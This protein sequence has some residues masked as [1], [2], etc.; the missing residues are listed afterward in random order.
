MLKRINALLLILISIFLV[1]CVDPTQDTSKDAKTLIIRKITC[2]VGERVQIRVLNLEEGETV[3]FSYDSDAI[4][5]EDGFVEGMLAGQTVQV[6]ATSSKGGRGSFTVEVE[7]DNYSPTFDQSSWFNEINIDKVQNLRQDFPLGIDIST[8]YE[9]LDKGGKFYNHEGLRQ[10]VYQ[11]L[12]NNGVNYVRLRLW[13]DPYKTV[14]QN[15][16]EV[17]IPYGGGICDLP[18]ILEIARSAKKA[19]LKVLLDFHYSDFWADPSKQVIPKAWLNYT[20]SD[21]IAQ[22]IYDFTYQTIETLD[23]AGAKPDMVQ[24]GNEITPGMIIH[25][26]GA[27]EYIV[28]NSQPALSSAIRGSY[29]GASVNL[30]KYIKAGNDAVKDYDSD[31]LTVIHLAKG[32]SGTD[33]IKEFFHTFDSIDYDVIGLS[34]YPYW[35]GTVSQLG[36]TVRALAQEFPTKLIS[37]V[38]ISYGFTYASHPNANNIF[39]PSG[40]AKPVS[41]YS[42]NPQG[43]ADLLVDVISTLSA[44]SQGYGIFY[45]EGCWIPV[46]GV[47][48]AEAG[49]KNSWANQ[50]LFSYDGKALPS[51]RVFKDIK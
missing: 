30:K 9:V 42:V 10:N 35:H 21:Q 51:L 50:A 46:S 43:Q 47:G 1:S 28:E 23:K 11:I 27:N 39:S 6:S 13:N 29:S 18:R 34:Y 33:F 25:A 44:V 32:M 5:I 24:I 16:Q 15:G 8:L 3:S 17:K 48:W 7:E 40:N 45:W 26:P 41:G 12:K 4:Y 49:T 19:G 38:E 31:I 14:T 22:A 2:S 37:I 36:N 20:T